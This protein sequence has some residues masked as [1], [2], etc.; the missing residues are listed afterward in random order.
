MEEIAVDLPKKLL[1]RIQDLLNI[2]QQILEDQPSTNNH[3]ERF[4]RE[5][6]RDLKKMAK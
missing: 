5:I 2:Y 3:A 4:N 1:F 6:N